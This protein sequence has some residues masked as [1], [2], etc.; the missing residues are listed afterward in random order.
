ML[1]GVIVM[2]T[3]RNYQVNIDN[4][5]CQGMFAL[6]RPFFGPEYENNSLTPAMDVC[7]RG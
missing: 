3:T 2:L 6:A 4:K 1:Q 5:A 7:L